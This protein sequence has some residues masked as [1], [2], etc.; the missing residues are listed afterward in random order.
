MKYTSL[1]FPSYVRNYIEMIPKRSV[2]ISF[3]NK[4][5]ML[6]VMVKILRTKKEYEQQ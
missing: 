2:T 5:S 6:S 3:L 4:I 1:P